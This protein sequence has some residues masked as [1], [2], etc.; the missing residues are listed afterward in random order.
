MQGSYLGNATADTTSTILFNGIKWYGKDVPEHLLLSLCEML[1]GVLRHDGITLSRGTRELDDVR[2]I[3][4]H[5]IHGDFNNGLPGALQ[6]FHEVWL[7]SWCDG[8]L[9]YNN[10]RMADRHEH[11]GMIHGFA[12]MLGMKEHDPVIEV[13]RQF[14]EHHEVCPLT[15]RSV[16]DAPLAVNDEGSGALQEVVIEWCT[17]VDRAHVCS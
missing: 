13:L 5:L 2:A 15:E 7:V 11:I 6:V 8:V 4:A 9:A 17:E 10:P 12:R 14:A 3:G 16:E 1:P